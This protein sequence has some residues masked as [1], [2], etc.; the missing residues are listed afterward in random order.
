[1]EHRLERL[2]GRTEATTAVEWLRQHRDHGEICEEAVGDGAR[3]LVCECGT[4]VLCLRLRT[5]AA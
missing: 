5:E 2:V 3:R 1:M 4:R